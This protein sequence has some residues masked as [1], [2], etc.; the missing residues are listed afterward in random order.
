MASQKQHADRESIHAEL[1]GNPARLDTLRQMWGDEFFALQAHWF[2]FSLEEAGQKIVFPPFRPSDTAA[3][4]QESLVDQMKVRAEDYEWLM[5]NIRSLED[6]VR[7]LRAE[8]K[9]WEAQWQSVE[10]SAG[11]RLLGSWRRTRD[12]LAPQGTR[13]R[14]LY[15]WLMGKS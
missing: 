9:R 8:K 11:W 10:N 4:E 15:N 5:Q 6:E 2:W 12:R 3:Q 1:A 7:Q 13:R 14:G